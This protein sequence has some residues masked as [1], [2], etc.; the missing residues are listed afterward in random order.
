MDLLNRGRRGRRLVGWRARCPVSHGNSPHRPKEE[1][2]ITDAN[3]WVQSVM[4][5]IVDEFD[6]TTQRYP[7]VPPNA[8]DPYLPPRR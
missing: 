8:S 7:H 6:A 2:D 5:R 4:D 1:T 3:P